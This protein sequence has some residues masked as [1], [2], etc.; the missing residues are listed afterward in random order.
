MKKFSDFK[1]I[2][3]PIIIKES[4]ESDQIEDVQITQVAY[5]TDIAKFFSKLFE[6]REVAHIYHLQIQGE[7]SYVAHLAL[8]EY[9]DN[10]LE[11]IDELIEVYQGQ[12]D[13]IENY[14][15]INPD[16]TLSKD[17]IDYFIE[18]AD[19]IKNNKNCILP[20]DTH[21]LSI[22]DEVL[23]LIYKTLYKLKTLK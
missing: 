17:K 1:P 12:Y 16:I 9:Y 10:I 7:G 3:K 18:L 5:Q 8:N 22:V 11:L 19:F 4:D 15:I 14:D 23:I 2:K 21:L 13:I 20:D 6:S